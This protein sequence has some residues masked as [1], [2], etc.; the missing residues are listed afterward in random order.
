MRYELAAPTWGPEEFAAIDRVVARGRF[1]MGDEVAAF[2]REFAD[3]FGSKYG[4]MVN[5]RSSANLVAVAAL[6]Y[7]PE[8]PLQRCYAAIVPAVLSATS[9]HPL[10]QHRL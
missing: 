4:V 3:Y 5:S 9:C 2:E 6:F 7:K 1:T 8:R 10:Q